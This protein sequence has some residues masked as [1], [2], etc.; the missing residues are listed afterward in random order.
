MTVRAVIFDWGGTLTPY[1]QLDYVEVWRQ[2]A[3]TLDPARA[4]DL[5]AALLGAEEELW[6]RAR[7]EQRSGHMAEVCAAAGIPLD[8]AYRSAFFQ[9]WEAHTYTDPDADALLREL[10]ARDIVVGLLSNTTWPRDWLDGVLARDGVLGHFDAT[11]YSCEL[12]CVKP[13]PE[14]FRHAMERVGVQT[15][16]SA[17]YVGDRAYDDVYGAQRAGMRTVLVPHSDIPAAERW[18]EPAEPDATVQCL[19]DLLPLVDEWR[20]AG[21]STKF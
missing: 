5:T 21:K 1:H 9:A 11:V 8:D 17:V 3:R 14:A 7:E 13:H 12:D 18:G 2:V 16:A 4:D 19:A 15:P 6:R 10:R 20:A